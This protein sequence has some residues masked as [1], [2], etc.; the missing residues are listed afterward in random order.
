MEVLKY[1]D[2]LISLSDQ[3]LMSEK[4]RHS[5]QV[6]YSYMAS[7]KQT[8]KKTTAHL[9]INLLSEGYCF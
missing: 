2:S 4:Q 8:N 5:T 9:V 3:P 6:L 7:K 1:L